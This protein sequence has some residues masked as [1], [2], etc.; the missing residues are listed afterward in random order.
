MTFHDI[1][2]ALDPEPAEPPSYPY[3]VTVEF[4]VY[5]ESEDEALDVMDNQLQS[6]MQKTLLAPYHIDKAE[7]A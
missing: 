1:A 2:Q 7:E 5:A 4:T 6:A 3:T